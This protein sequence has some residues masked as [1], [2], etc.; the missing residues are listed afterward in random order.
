MDQSPVFLQ[1]NKNAAE[2][3]AWSQPGSQ[4]LPK[5]C[6]DL[7][8]QV[9]FVLMGGSAAGVWVEGTSH[10]LCVVGKIPRK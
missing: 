5:L 1:L 8:L 2:F 7:Q 6:I 4:Q 10:N 3:T 9:C